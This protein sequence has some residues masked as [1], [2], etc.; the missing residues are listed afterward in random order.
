MPGVGLDADVILSVGQVADYAAFFVFLGV[1][2][3]QV[4][5]R[6]RELP[7][8]NRQQDQQRAVFAERVAKPVVAEYRHEARSIGVSVSKIKLH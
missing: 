1:V 7:E 3:D 5:R 6:Q 4:V 2:D 8:Q